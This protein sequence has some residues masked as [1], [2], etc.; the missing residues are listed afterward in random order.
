MQKNRLEA[1]GSVELDHESNSTIQYV[2]RYAVVAGRDIW[3]WQQKGTFVWAAAKTEREAIDRIKEDAAKRG[4]APS[5]S[6]ISLFR[7][8]P[9]QL[10]EIPEASQ[11]VRET[12]TREAVSRARAVATNALGTSV[13]IVETDTGSGVYRGAVID[14]TEHYVLQRQSMRTAV[15]HPKQLLD[16]QPK[17]GENVSINY[18]NARGLVRHARGPAKAQELGR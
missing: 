11:R 13:R 18:S 9:E 12:A 6:D 1:A 17:A 3:K 15:L 14:E 7:P 16:R 4:S 2:Y 10:L 5:I 8:R